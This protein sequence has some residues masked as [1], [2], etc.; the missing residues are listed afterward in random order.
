MTRTSGT[1]RSGPV[2]GASALFASSRP[3]EQVQED[4]QASRHE[5]AVPECQGP[6]QVQR[7]QD[8]EPEVQR[9]RGDGPPIRGRPE[10]GSKQELLSIA[11]DPAALDSAVERFRGI[12][13]APG[14]TASKSTRARLW[15]DFAKAHSIDEFP[16]TVD[17]IMAFASALREAGYRSGYFYLC[18]VQ[19]LHVRMGYEVTGPMQ[20]A[21]ADAKRGLERGIGAPTRSAEVRAEWWNQLQEKIQRGEVELHRRGA[22]PRGGLHTWGFGTAWLLRELELAMLDVH[23]D[24]IKID[25]VT[26]HATV[27]IATSKADPR[28]RGASRTIACS[29]SGRSS[30]SC[31]ACCA[32]V[33]LSLAMEAWGGDRQSDEARKVPLIG[34]VSEPGQIVQKREF[35]QAVQADAG[36]LV[37]MGLSVQPSAVTGHFMRRSGAKSLARAGVPLAKIQWMGRWGSSAVLAY[38]EEAAEEAPECC[39]IDA[40]GPSWEEVRADVANLLRLSGP[41]SVESLMTSAAV[42]T[43]RVT[44]LEQFLSTARVEIGSVSAL[45][46]EL[47]ALVRPTLVLNT[48]TRVAHRALRTER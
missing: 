16:F 21:M 30:P 31:G 29:C 38:V 45:A 7:P 15:K 33:L 3:A 5:G 44:A 18:E 14:S 8:Q 13:Y 36:L 25:D 35:V 17:K 2:L 23:A 47:D 19:Q 28:G 42:T 9:R 32:K 6:E 40:P 46:H 27:R 37:D 22:G 34:T 24:T 11:K 10:K 20:V 12:A 26:G 48:Q 43:D 1:S 4:R 41:A 39:T